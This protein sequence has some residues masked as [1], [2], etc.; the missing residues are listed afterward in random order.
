MSLQRKLTTFFSNKVRNNIIVS[1]F[2]LLLQC[3]QLAEMGRAITT[4]IHINL[5]K[6]LDN[7]MCVCVRCGMV[8]SIP[9]CPTAVFLLSTLLNYTITMEKS[10]K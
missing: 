7:R 3:V 8:L 2:P 9:C 10:R 5:F 6:T 4:Y 1:L